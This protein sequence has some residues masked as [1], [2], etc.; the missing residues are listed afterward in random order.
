MASEPI[1]VDGLLEWEGY[2]TNEPDIVDDEESGVVTVVD[3]AG[4]D[5]DGTGSTRPDCTCC[6]KLGGTDDD[7][8]CGKK[9]LAKKR[10]RNFR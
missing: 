9:L 4:D 5:E 1:D 2:A 6:G 8:N 10:T 3:K 7:G